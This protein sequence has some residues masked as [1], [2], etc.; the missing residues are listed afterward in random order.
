MTEATW[1]PIS[2]APCTDTWT[3]VRYR[4]GE[5]HFTD[6]DHDSDPTWWAAHGATHWRIPTEQEMDAFFTL[7]SK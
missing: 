4:N 6:L 2:S 3:I 7:A 5:E 1:H